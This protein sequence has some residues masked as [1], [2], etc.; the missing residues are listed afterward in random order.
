MTHSAENTASAGATLNSVTFQMFI[1]RYSR[2]IFLFILL[3]F[4]SVASDTFWGLTNWTNIAN[5]ASIQV[6]FLIILTLG[7]NLTII[8]RG[9]DLSV[10]SNLAMSS[11]ITALCLEAGMNV[12]LS[13]LIGLAFGTLVGITNGVLIGVIGVSPFIATYSMS[14]IIRGVAYLLLA[15]RQIYNLGDT[16]VPLFTSNRWTFFIIAIAVA[17]VLWFI[18]TKTVFGRSFYLAGRNFEAVSL[19]GYS[20]QK[21]TIIVYAISGCLAALAGILYVADLSCA[22]PTIGEDFPL[23]AVA[24][25]LIGGTSFIGG[26]GSVFNAIVGSFVLMVIMNGMIQMGVPNLWQ[27]FVIGVIIILSLV[28]EL[29]TARIEKNISKVLY[30]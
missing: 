2:W 15:G 18:M 17:V 23:Q 29:G 6:P 25:A 22:E 13:I 16:F 5:I 8:L 7:M 11:C 28:I 1:V 3:V 27:Q 21:I 10:G 30:S 19:S 4:F 20:V 12:A 14:W 26:E 24:A 9:F